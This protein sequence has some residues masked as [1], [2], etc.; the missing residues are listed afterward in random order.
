MSKF[1]YRL[2]PLRGILP[3]KKTNKL[4]GLYLRRHNCPRPLQVV[5]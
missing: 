1:K 4:C 5:T 3:V 2:T